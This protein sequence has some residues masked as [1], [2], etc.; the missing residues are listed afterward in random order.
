MINSDTAKATVKDAGVTTSQRGKDTFSLA[1]L[2]IVMTD[3]I[4]I[5]SVCLAI[6]KRYGPYT[7]ETSIQ[8]P[9]H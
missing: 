3:E 2:Q 9:S 4:K 7:R 6:L 8:N 1:S 5:S